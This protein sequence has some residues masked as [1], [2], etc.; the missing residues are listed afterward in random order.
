MNSLYKISLLA[1]ALG[2]A[3]CGKTN[4][5][6]KKQ[7]VY[8]KKQGYNNEI[9]LEHSKPYKFNIDNYKLHVKGEFSDECL[10]ID[11][12]IDLV[13]DSDYI[14]KRNYYVA[15]DFNCS[16]NINSVKLVSESNDQLVYESGDKFII[17]ISDFKRNNR[18][19]ILYNNNQK[20]KNSVI[21]LEFDGAFNNLKIKLTGPM[22]ISE[23]EEKSEIK[24]ND[25]SDAKN[26]LPRFGKN[27]FRKYFYVSSDVYAFLNEKNEYT[28]G[29]EISV[30]VIG[31][32]EKLKYLFIEETSSDHAVIMQ[33]AKASQAQAKLLDKDTKISFFNLTQDFNFPKLPENTESDEKIHAK[34]LDKFNSIKLVIIKNDSEFNVVTF[35]K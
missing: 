19:G 24:L 15:Q 2:V 17:S 29:G 13:F 31:F 7:K 3:S 33:K 14:L 4:A 10:R 12:S 21:K 11:K 22:D 6:E 23:I 20:N 26:I 30:T 28:Y 18:T 35:N 34:L 25:N 5:N 1:I 16:M 32:D 8:V 9:Y 27:E